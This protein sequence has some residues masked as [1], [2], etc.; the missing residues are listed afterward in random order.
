MEA[1]EL[2]NFSVEELQARIRQW[3]DELF[4]ARFRQQ[5]PEKRDTSIYKKLRK[6]IARGETVLVEKLKGATP[7][8]TKATAP[9]RETKGTEAKAAPA[10]VV[11]EV[12]DKPSAKKGIGKKKASKREGVSSNAK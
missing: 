12:Q 2:R 1:A 11:E 7:A 4:R 5:T 10:D 3:R 8:A 9:I 6:D